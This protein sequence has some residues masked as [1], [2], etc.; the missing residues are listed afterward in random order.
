LGLRRLTRYN[1]RVI[2]SGG[3]NGLEFRKRRYTSLG[4]FLADFLFPVRYGFR[5]REAE[6]RG[7]LSPALRERLMMAVT[8]VNECRYCSYVHAREAL[9]T[10]IAPDE[11]RRLL[12]GTVDDSPED[13]V[14]ALLYAQHWAESDAQPAPDAVERCSTHTVSRRPTPLTWCSG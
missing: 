8:A 7:L 10:G 4:N 3:R 5:L 14:A 12:S 1:S 2:P 9:K 11:V 13:D 6:R